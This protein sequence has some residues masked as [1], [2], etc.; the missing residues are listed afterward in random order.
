MVS[1]SSGPVCVHV[2]LSMFTVLWNLRAQG[3]LCYFLGFVLVTVLKYGVFQR[4]TRF[5]G[6]NDSEG[7]AFTFE[8]SILW[9]GSF[10]L[11]GTDPRNLFCV[12]VC[13]MLACVLCSP[14]IHLWS[15]HS[16]AGSLCSPL[17]LLRQDLEEPGAHWCNWAGQLESLGDPLVSTSWWLGLQVCTTVLAFIWVLG[18][19]TWVLLLQPQ[20]L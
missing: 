12:C 17:Y 1:S 5:S 18:I 13:C 2:A 7:C 10:R 11:L 16:E 19:R 8:K 14:H 15:S 6:F 3:R 9:Q 20:W 4:M